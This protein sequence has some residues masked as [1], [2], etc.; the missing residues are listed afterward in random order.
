MRTAYFIISGV[1]S[2]AYAQLIT[3]RALLGRQDAD[4]DSQLVAP[5]VFIKQ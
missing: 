3:P 4:C 5:F 1:A 2:V